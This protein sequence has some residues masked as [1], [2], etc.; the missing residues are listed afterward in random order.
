MLENYSPNFISYVY[1]LDDDNLIKDNFLDIV[2]EINP[3]TDDIII[4]R[5]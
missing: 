1:M 3:E 2:P 5:V 4:F